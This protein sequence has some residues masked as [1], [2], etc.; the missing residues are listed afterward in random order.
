MKI[1]ICFLC[2]FVWCRT[3]SV[4][5]ADILVDRSCN[6]NDENHFHPNRNISV[7]HLGIVRS[8]MLDILVFAYKRMCNDNEEINDYTLMN[9]Y[10]KSSINLELMPV[11][12]K[13]KATWPNCQRS[14]L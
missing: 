8:I 14:I 11:N 9:D 5:Y 2:L 13:L 12:K 3:V 7:T 10:G 4:K 1:Y 6:L